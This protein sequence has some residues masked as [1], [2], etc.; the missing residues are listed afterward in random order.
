MSIILRQEEQKAV[1]TS[2]NLTQTSASNIL[3]KFK[4]SRLKTVK[5][6]RLHE[7]IRNDQKSC[8]V[9]FCNYYNVCGRE[10]TI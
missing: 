2:T 1:I 10:L 3:Q 8:D 5:R 7:M 4:K 6:K 9:V